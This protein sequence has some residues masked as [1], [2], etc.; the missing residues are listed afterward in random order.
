MLYPHLP[1]NTTRATHHESLCLGGL[2]SADRLHGPFLAPSPRQ[3]GHRDP[4]RAADVV[5][6]AMR[7][8]SRLEDE[9]PSGGE[10]RECVWR[11]WWW[12]WWGGG[13]LK[14]TRPYR[15]CRT[16]SRRN[17]RISTRHRSCCSSCFCFSFRCCCSLCSLRMCASSPPPL[18]SA[19]WS[20]TTPADAL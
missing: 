14:Q 6:R 3:L 17:D 15:S 12:W 5:A 2:Q 11:W 13:S 8:G 20:R 4:D 19:P 7:V 1:H 10:E 16:S 18:A 9:H